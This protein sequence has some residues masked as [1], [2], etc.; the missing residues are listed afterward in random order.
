VLN[1]CT[2]D[3]VASGGPYN[4]ERTEYTTGEICVPDNNYIFLIRDT[5]G[6]GMVLGGSYTVKYDGQEV[7]TYRGMFSFK[8]KSHN[9]GTT[10]SCPSVLFPKVNAIDYDAQSGTKLVNNGANIGYI[11]NN[12]YLTYNNLNFGPSGTT[13]S[14]QLRYSK[15]RNNRG[16]KVELRI[17]GPNGRLIG[18]FSPITTGSWYR[19]H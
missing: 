1:K 4:Q 3:T 8:Y 19:V 10:V 16:G 12:D 6:D 2:G 11:S 7:G 18:E 13:K 9:F 15:K 5:F 17:G 14:V